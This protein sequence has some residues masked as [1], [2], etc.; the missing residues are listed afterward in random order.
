MR[1]PVR[2]A[3]LLAACAAEGCGVRPADPGGLVIAV[4]AGPVSLDPRLGSDEGSRRFQDLV[5]NSLYRTGDDARPEPDLA[6][7]LDR[8]DPL[9]LV[10][11]LA[12][13][14][15]FH[16]G[17]LLTSADVAATY[18]AVIDG[19]VASFRRADLDSIASIDTPDPRTVVFRLGRPFAPLVSNL[20]LPILRAGAG[21]ETARRPI[22]TGPFRLER[23]RR[24]EDLLLLRFDGYFEGKSAITSLRL[25]VIPSETARLLELLTGGVDLVVNDLAPDGVARARRDAAVRILTRTGRNAV[26]MAFNLRDPLL[27]D[28]RVRRGIALAIDREAVRAH[29]LAGAATLATGLLPPGH[30]AY[31]PAVPALTRD[32]Q[33]AGRLLD[34][35]GYPDPDGPGPLVRFRVEY[36]APASEQARQQAAAFQ[37]QLFDA[38]I[39]VDVRTYEWATF[40]EDL[41][42]GRFQIVV[43]NW[44]DLSDPD[45]YRLRFH[46]GALP[47]AGLNRG[48]YVSAEADRL[49][50]AGA[51]SDDPAARKAAYDRLQELLALDLPYIV[52]WHRDVVA[53]IGPRVGQFTLRSGADFRPLWKARARG[54][55][56]RASEHL[57][58][59][60]PRHGTRAQEARRIDG[61]IDE[62]R[63]RPA[64]GA[65][66]VEHDRDA[67]AESVEHLPGDI[68]RVGA[69]AVGAGGD[70]RPA[71]GARE[72][73][74]DR[75]R[76]DAHA[77]RGPAAQKTRR[78]LRRGGEDQGER[79]G[80]EGLGEPR[81]GRREGA[82]HARGRVAV[83]GEQRQRHLLGAALGGENPLDRLGVARVTGHRVE[84]LGRVGDEESPLERRGGLLDRL[85]RRILRIER[86]N[87]G[88]HAGLMVGN[89]TGGTIAQRPVEAA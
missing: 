63:G 40:Y 88:R 33:Q 42:A 18:R 19:S 24:D 84:G 34:E 36:K 72:G 81:R 32:L 5:F 83:G 35:A 2:L 52:L 73:A 80:P 53:A 28:I 60:V 20:T 39:G 16:D 10:V 26:Y 74:R 66:A 65:A 37:A 14:V 56:E 64:A 79:P 25:R 68:G 78:Q 70:D 85:G 54:S 38:G 55:G 58:E 49:I 22:G 8:P 69:G 44:T 48:G 43:S 27:S 62:R 7:R 4:D 75:M 30:W 1:R 71:E 86:Q 57:L 47:P 50:E 11:T 41:R 87:R 17:A 15:R 13:G 51:G 12:D 77:D 89:P 46:S 82:R 3:I 45:V 29:L 6:V 59:E 76:G 61:E 31:N 21:P 67:V 9:T 23:Y